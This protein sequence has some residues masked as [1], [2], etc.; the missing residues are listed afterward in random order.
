M[1]TRIQRRRSRGWSLPVGAVYVRRGRRLGYLS[2]VA[3]A[4]CVYVGARPRRSEAGLLSSEPLGGSGCLL[5]SSVVGPA[6]GACRQGL[7]MSV[8]GVD[9]VT[10]TGLLVLV[11]AMWWRGPAGARRTRVG[12]RRI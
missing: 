11:A 10:R 1:P 4:V 6:V 7:S 9:G 5:V 12:S 8:G 3:S 2:W